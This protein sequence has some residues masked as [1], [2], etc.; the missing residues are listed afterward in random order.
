VLFTGIVALLF[1]ERLS[2]TPDSSGA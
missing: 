2:G 1:R